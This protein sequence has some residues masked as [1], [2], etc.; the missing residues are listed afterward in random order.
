MNIFDN[1]KNLARPYDAGDDYDDYDDYDD[2]FD[3]EEESTPRSRRSERRSRSQATPFQTGTSS[4]VEEDTDSDDVFATPGFSNTGVSGGFTGH[5]VGSNTSTSA[6]SDDKGGPFVLSPT[7]FEESKPCA[8]HMLKDRGVILDLRG[9]DE[10]LRCRIV[11]F[12]SG[13]AYAL[14]GGGQRIADQIFAF[15]PKGREV[16]DLRKK[17]DD[18]DSPTP[19]TESYI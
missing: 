2:G 12:L 10:Q 8:Q 17:D 9:V 13:C 5:V 11:D 18:F 16:T 14:D 4:D 15:W 7:S 19:Q 6:S 3:E 1:L